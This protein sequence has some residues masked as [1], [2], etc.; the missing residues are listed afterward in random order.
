MLCQ[1]H[2][3][4]IS[5]I[6]VAEELIGSNRMTRSYPVKGRIAQSSLDVKLLLCELDITSPQLFIFRN[7]ISCWATQTQS[8]KTAT[9]LL[10]S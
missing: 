10:L 3:Y 1:R 4:S 5:N 9:A 6:Y 8:E 2:G 7:V